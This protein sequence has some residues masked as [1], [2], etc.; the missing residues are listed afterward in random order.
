VVDRVTAGEPAPPGSSS[1][2]DRLVDAGA[3]HPRPERGPYTEVDV[4]VVIPVRDHDVGGVVA[5]VGRTVPVVVV[6][7]GSDPP[8][9]V[10]GAT[11]LRRPTSGGPAAARNTGLAAVATPVIAFVDADC[12]PEPGWLAPLLNQF[13]DDRVAAVAPRI[14]SPA[15]SGAS[16]LAR[17]ESVRSPLDLGPDEARVRAGTRVAY[18]PA[19]ALVVRTDA[20]VD[21][22][23]FDEGLRWG[24]DVDL[25]WRLDEAGRRVRYVPASVVDHAPRPTLWAWMAQRVAYGSSAADL[26]VRHPGAVPPVAVSAWSAVVWALAVGGAPVPAALVGAG[27]ATAL[28]RKLRGLEHPLVEAFSLAG[29]GHL[30]AGR[31]LAAAVTRAW[32]PVLLLGATRSR[33]LRRALLAAAFIPPVVDWMRQR[34]PVDIV[35]YTALRLLDDASYSVGVWRGALRR[36]TA[37]PLLPDFTSWPRPSRYA[38]RAVRT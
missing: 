33:R 23:G 21:L 2:T 15:D 24:E 32:W 7:D 8:V 9:R 17:Y 11:M 6:D 20:L 27:T 19:A 31:L 12:A 38:R 36:R 26:A 14:A 10:D 37:A 29:R 35:R 4:T 28:A 5:A 30:F 22:G 13:A 34:P 1:L 18:V 25:V 16:V 3:L